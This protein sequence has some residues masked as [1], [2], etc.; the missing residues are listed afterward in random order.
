MKAALRSLARRFACAWRPRTL[1]LAY[2]HVGDLAETAPWVTVS[3]A[4]FA[5]QMAFLA[6]SR[7]VVSLDQLLAELRLRRLPRGGNVVLTF[8]DAAL[9]TWTTAFPVLRRY[10][11]PATLFVPTGLVGRPQP[12]W[13]DRLAR[14]TRAAAAKGRS[15]TQFLVGAGVVE[16]GHPG[17]DDKLWRKVRL[18]GPERREQALDSATDWLAEDNAAVARSGDRAAQQGAMDWSHI[19]QLDNSGLMTL[20]AHTISHPVLAA[21]DEEELATEIT[22]CRDRLREF[23]SF[24][25]VFAYPYG[26]APAIGARVEQAVRQAGF[27]AAF[28]TEETALYGRE[29]PMRLG[30]VCVDDMTLCDFRRAIDDHLGS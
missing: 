21:I 10:G 13:W 29:E 3:P 1:V 15:L 2:H 19:A 25:K 18:L 5:E 20:G 22:G 9:N 26:D 16:N 23:S 12:F 7:L 8:D 27:E 17:N 11:L 28:T 4:R 6:D 24:R 30:R 14:L